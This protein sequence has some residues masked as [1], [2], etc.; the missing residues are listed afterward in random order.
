MSYLETLKTVGQ[1]LTIV[2][3][4]CGYN[5]SIWYSTNFAWLENWLANMKAYILTEGHYIWQKKSK[6]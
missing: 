1:W 5:T 4:R 3:A 2:K 6:K